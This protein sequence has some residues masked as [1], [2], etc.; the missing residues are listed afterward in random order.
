MTLLQGIDQLETHF[1]QRETHVL[2][3]VP[4]VGRFQRLRREALVLLDR[5]PSKKSRPPLFGILV[6][7]KDMIRVEGFPTG[8]G[9][10][11]PPEVLQGPEAECVTRLRQAGA[12][13]LGRTQTSEFAYSAPTPTRNPHHPDHTPGGSSSGSAAA[14][15]AG[16][17]PA[18]QE[19]SNAKRK[20][21]KIE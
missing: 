19:N 3:F 6:G 1:G 2:A 16:L 15:A 13:I 12:L 21:E 11:L 4:E 17:C 7:V 14:V 18:I 5:Y 9:S 20:Q 8:A 10:Q